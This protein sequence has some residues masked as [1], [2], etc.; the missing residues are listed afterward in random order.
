MMSSSDTRVLLRGDK[1][2]ANRRLPFAMELH[3]QF[4]DYGTA[5]DSLQPVDSF[6]KQFEW[7]SVRC[8]RIHGQSTLV[9]TAKEYGGRGGG[10]KDE[11]FRERDGS[12]LAK[13]ERVVLKIFVH[14]DRLVRVNYNDEYPGPRRNVGDTASAIAIG[15][16]DMDSRALLAIDTKRDDYLL[17]RQPPSTWRSNGYKSVYDYSPNT[18]GLCGVYNSLVPVTVP[19]VDGVDAGW[20]VVERTS[21]VITPQPGETNKERWKVNGYAIMGIRAVDVDGRLRLPMI[22]RNDTCNTTKTTPVDYMLNP[23]YDEVQCWPPDDYVRFTFYNIGQWYNPFEQPGPPTPGWNSVG[24]HEVNITGHY[25]IHGVNHPFGG[26]IYNGY[27]SIES[28]DY[29]YRLEPTPFTPI[30]MMQGEISNFWQTSS[31]YQATHDNTFPLSNFHVGGYSFFCH[32]ITANLCTRDTVNFTSEYTG[33]L[34][35]VTAFCGAQPI[36]PITQIPE[37]QAIVDR[38]K[39]VVKAAIE[40][41]GGQVF[42]NSN[43]P[44]FVAQNP[45]GY[46]W[47][48]NGI[49]QF[50][51]R[52]RRGVMY[53]SPLMSV[54][55]GATLARETLVVERKTPTVKELQHGT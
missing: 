54:I 3:R 13:K 42:S 47:T 33:H 7:G 55:I 22:Y 35:F 39:E 27:I 52:T 21:V 51:V 15:V 17:C 16:I 43:I 41:A 20:S 26:M 25:R 9:V 50:D 46:Y 14:V 24:E 32:Q 28:G 2:E 34:L 18:T 29:Q 45:D 40:A 49:T 5:T 44:A 23:V 6:R 12:E 31:G 4:R 37:D 19:G 36:L 30:D 53:T 1:E 11:R 38:I 8:V 48:A 10:D